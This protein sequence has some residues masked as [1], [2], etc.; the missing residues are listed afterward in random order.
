MTP[1]KLLTD[2]NYLR[3]IIISYIPT[4]NPF[5]KKGSSSPAYSAMMKK[6]VGGAQFVH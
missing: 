5:K 2:T 6:K 4:N 3:E 1:Y